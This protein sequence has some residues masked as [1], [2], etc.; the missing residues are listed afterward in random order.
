M[1][2]LSMRITDSGVIGCSSSHLPPIVRGGGYKPPSATL[3]IAQHPVGTE[4]SGRVL[5]GGRIKRP[6]ATPTI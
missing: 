2:I 6:H 1:R 5:R 4:S 3:T